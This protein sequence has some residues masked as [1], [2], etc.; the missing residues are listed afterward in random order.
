MA[1]GVASFALGIDTA[2]SG[3]VPAALNN[4]V[5]LKGTKGLL[6]TAS[7]V[8]DSLRVAMQATRQQ[9]RKPAACGVFTAR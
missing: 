9:V 6:S 5:G 1:L 7:V 3:R 8:G 2:G 4:L